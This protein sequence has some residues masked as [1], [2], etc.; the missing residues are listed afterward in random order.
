MSTNSKPK[1]WELKPLWCQP[2]SIIAFGIFLIFSTYYFSKN[3]FITS[4]LIF[5]ILIW[6]LLFLVLAPKLYIK[7]NEDKN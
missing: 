2:W 5:I 3:I 4:I 6:W 1:Y 7:S